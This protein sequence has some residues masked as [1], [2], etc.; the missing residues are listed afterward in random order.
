MKI[1]DGIAAYMKNHPNVYVSV[2]GHCDERASEAYN[3]A[4]G[5][6]R[7]NYVRTL[8]IQ[9]GVNKERVHSSSYGKEQPVDLGHSPSAWARN[10][11][12]EFK[13]YEK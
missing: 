11:R 13:I 9:R 7:S 4:L 6:R 5:T 1:I 3:L 10:R 2:V 12:A 8:L